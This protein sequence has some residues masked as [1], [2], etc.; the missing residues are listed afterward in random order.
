MSVRRL[1]QLLGGIRLRWQK[2]EPNSCAVDPSYSKHDITQVPR[3]AAA[4]FSRALWRSALW[5]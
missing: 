5:G 1:A 3:V 4:A 2:V